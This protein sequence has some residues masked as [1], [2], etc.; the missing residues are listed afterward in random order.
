MSTS[1]LRLQMKNVCKS[2]R[3]VKALRGV[4]FE[5]RP[6]EV[7]ALLGENG[8][9]K[10]TL[11]KVLAGLIT[12][13][14]GEISIDGE[15]VDL[16]SAR[17]SR[18]AGVAV[19]QQEFS[20][21]PAMTVA[22]NLA[23]G[24]DDVAAIASRGR[25]RTA[26]RPL[27]A[28]VGLEHIDPLARVETL[29]VA[30]TQLLEVARVLAVDAR[31][32]IF[33]E[34]TAALSDAEITRVLA[35]VR[36]LADEGRSI[37][38]VTHRLGEVFE[39]SDRVTIFRNGSSLAAQSTQ[40]L[41]VETVVT[42]MLGREL[43]QMYPA[44]TGQAG[45][46]D[47]LVV[48]RLT[49]PGITAP[50]TAH[51][52]R[53]EIIGITGQIGSGASAFIETLA[54][55]QTPQSGSVTLAGQPLRP[56]RRRGIARGVAYCSP[57]RKR[58]GVFLN[59][60]ISRNL[61]SPWLHA[62][63]RIGLL[64]KRAERAE[65]AQAAARFAIDS[66]RMGSATGDLSGG[67][68]QKVALGKWHG[69]N[70]SVLLVEEPTRGVDVGARAE[71]YTQLRELADS[72]MLVIINSSDTAEVF[73]LADRIATFYRGRMSGLRPFTELTEQQVVTEVMHTDL[74]P[75]D[76]RINEEVS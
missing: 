32:I 53:G 21:I 8:A 29:S 26:C 63:A 6:G 30:E 45:D 46:G 12:P 48:E 70:P 1:P 50:V 16:S 3:A 54:G 73:G 36:Q 67:N 75:H 61:S 76:I 56:G 59:L 22:E 28:R 38:Y 43:E 39:I 52:K 18:A 72:G 15:I 20:S 40:D 25:L 62:V 37:I 68:Q 60:S 33:D 55:L 58:D 7:M 47:L 57:D 69:I 10:S 13:D 23:L 64:N 9:G 14:D 31:V 27:L 71:I 41:S 17:K 2:Y 65:A 35:L 34:P 24:R 74:H 49:G 5:L 19:V 44:R 11:V 66:K 51:F 42:T 4:D